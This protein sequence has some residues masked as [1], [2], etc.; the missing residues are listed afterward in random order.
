MSGT[1]GETVGFGERLAEDAAAAEAGGHAIHRPGYVEAP[2]RIA[3]AE[4]DE[5]DGAVQPQ[6]LRLNQE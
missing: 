5:V 4:A 3:G 2:A 6:I 1:D